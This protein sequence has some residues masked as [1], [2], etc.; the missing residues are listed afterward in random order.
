MQLR[1]GI[2]PG[3]R[4]MAAYLDTLLKICDA[5]PDAAKQFKF[6]ITPAIEAKLGDDIKE[7]V[8]AHSHVLVC[9]VSGP[10]AAAT[11]DKVAQAVPGALLNEVAVQ[12]KPVYYNDADVDPYLP[13]EYFST[14]LSAFFAAKP[15]APRARRELQLEE[16]T[17][18][19]TLA[20]MIPPGAA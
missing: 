17:A 11:A 16:A 2:H 5:Y 4:D 14:N 1:F 18:A 6:L 8:R 15:Q 20:S 19:D 10:Q 13:R 7:K 3:V 12:G 9:D